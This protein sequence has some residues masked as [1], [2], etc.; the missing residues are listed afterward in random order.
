MTALRIAEKGKA[1]SLLTPAKVFR[2]H[3]GR[4]YNL[5]QRM[6]SNDADAQD[7]TQQVFV[8]VIRKLPTFRH[9]AA[10]ST[11]LYRVTVNAAIAYRR[12]RAR[13]EEH[14]VA[15]PLE[16]FL[17]DGRHCVPIRRWDSEPEKVILEREARLL[18]EEAI[19]QLPEKY[20]DVIVLADVEEQSN[21][22]VSE[23]L[24]L[25][26]PAVK[27]RLHRGRLLLRHALAPY[28]EER[29]A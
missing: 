16:H 25:S 11:W 5:A 4:V 9:E 22:Q 19:A 10:F 26:V 27:S 1:E 24:G 14:L 8:Q 7:V 20:R 21:F 13:R 12:K 3:A 29:A 23:F 6:L 2:E 17:A 18:I 15:D 28:F